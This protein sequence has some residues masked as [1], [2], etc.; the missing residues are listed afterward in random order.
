MIDAQLLFDMAQLWPM[1]KANYEALDRLQIKEVRASAPSVVAMFNPER[2]RSTAAK[3]DSA[4]VSA[5]PCF[6]CADNRPQEQRSILWRDYDVLVNP[7]PIFRHHLTIAS[8]SH[9]PQDFEGRAADMFALACELP[10][11][12]VFFNGP[13][14]GASAPDHLHF[15]AGDGLF[16]PSPLQREVDAAAQT[17]L[18]SEADGGSVLVSEATGRLVYHVVASSEDGAATLIHR[19]FAVRR[20]RK[21]MMNVVARARG[22]SAMVDFYFVP[23][24]L[25]RPWQFAATDESNILISP[26]AV[27]V[28][29]IFILPRLSDFDALTPSLASD[30]LMQVC[31]QNDSSLLPSPPYE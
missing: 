5:R 20:I 30:I 17:V 11:F 6:L 19:L 26:A 10:G 31:Y 29:G 23:R 18:F 16:A 21:D 7:F 3:V 8:R 27:E 22:A 25:F 15:Q 12:S 13:L 24:R 4:S 9:V 1:A 2:V 28:A 14:C